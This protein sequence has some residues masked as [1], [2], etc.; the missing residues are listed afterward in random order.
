MRVQSDVEALGQ[1]V[2]HLDVA[3]FDETM[4]AGEFVAVVLFFLLERRI[5]IYANTYLVPVLERDLVQTRRV[6]KLEIGHV[7]VEHELFLGSE[8]R[9]FGLQLEQSVFKRRVVG[10]IVASLSS[11]FFLTIYL[12]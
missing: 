12:A 5:K 6:G 9:L 11:I 2:D 4:R 7:P 8:R 1:P 10:L 3:V